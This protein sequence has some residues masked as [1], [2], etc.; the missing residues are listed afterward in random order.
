MGQLLRYRRICKC[1]ACVMTKGVLSGVE[2]GL[3]QTGSMRRQINVKRLT[4]YQMEKL[5]EERYIWNMY[6]V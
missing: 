3:E 6:D 5:K 2:A 4:L 1:N